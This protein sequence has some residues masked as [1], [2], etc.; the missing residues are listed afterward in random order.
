MAPYGVNINTLSYGRKI[1]FN[2]DAITISPGTG[3]SSIKYNIILKVWG[4]K[5]DTDFYS[6]P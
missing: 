3:G 5:M 6:Y 4:C 2:Q 1:T